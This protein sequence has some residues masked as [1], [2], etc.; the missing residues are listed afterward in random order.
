MCLNFHLFMHV[1]DPD[2][3]ICMRVAGKQR[4][5]LRQLVRNPGWSAPTVRIHVLANREP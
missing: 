4:V 3:V 2:L 1:F 5:S